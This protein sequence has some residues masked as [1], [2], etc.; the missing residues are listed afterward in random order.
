MALRVGFKDPSHFS[1]A[2]KARYGTS[3]ANCRT[4][5]GSRCRP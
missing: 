1:R 2:F 5:P 3:P 4:S